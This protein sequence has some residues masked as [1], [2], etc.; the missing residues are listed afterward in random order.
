MNK[1]HPRV[2]TEGG[3]LILLAA[4][5][6]LLPLEWVVAAICAATFHELC[7]YMLVKMVG[8]H[9]Y[10][11]RLG[12]SGAQLEVA[13]MSPVPEIL[14]AAAGPVGSALLVLT[15]RYTPRL[16]VCALVHCVFNLLPLFPSDGGR[17]LRGALTQFL[18]A[19][20]GER[21]FSASQKILIWGLLLACAVAALR[22]GVVP[23][24]FGILL[25]LRQRKRRTV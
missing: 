13:P 14:V 25:I 10:G 1:T 3:F 24:C 17:I 9:V 12:A 21:V 2:Q 19:G 5:I 11:L 7:H 15:A 4:M 20:V 16:A 23:V 22:V 18:P 6:L 8:G